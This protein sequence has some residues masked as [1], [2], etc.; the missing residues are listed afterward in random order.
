MH[1]SVVTVKSCASGGQLHEL[2]GLKPCMN[3]QFKLAKLRWNIQQIHVD[4]EPCKYDWT[5]RDAILVV[6]SEGPKEACN[7]RD[8]HWRQLANTIERSTCGDNV[9]FCQITLIFCVT[10][11]ILLAWAVVRYCDE[12]VCLCVCLSTMISLEPHAQSLPNFLRM[13]PMSVARSSSGMLI[14][15][16]IAYRREGGDGSAQCGRSVIY[17]CLVVVVSIVLL[18]LFLGLSN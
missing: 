14:V 12:Y 16:R 5:N 11:V 7:R 2:L 10:V 15:G 3:L 13:L 6:D 1:G 17:D 8:A 4:R 9:P 18:F